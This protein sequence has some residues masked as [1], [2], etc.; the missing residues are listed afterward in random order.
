VFRLLAASV[1]LVA[2]C[3]FE[4]GEIVRRDATDEQPMLDAPS[5]DAKPIDAPGA[6]ARVCPPPPSGCTRFTCSSTSSCYYVCGDGPGKATWAGAK[7]ICEGPTFQGCIL[8]LNSFDE[9]S[10]VTFN[11]GPTG[12]NPIWI[13]YR[14]DPAPM[15]PAGDWKWECGPSTYVQPGWAGISGQPDNNGGSANCALMSVAGAWA[16]EDCSGTTRY[17]CEV[18]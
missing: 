11:A 12:A 16:D 4:P 7:G 13:G 5:T 18:P 1:L 2:A 6:D 14:Q 8:T 15:E 3:G 9:Q 17:I 10:C